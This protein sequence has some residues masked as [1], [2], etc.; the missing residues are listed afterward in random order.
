M[1][2]IVE[3]L[4]YTYGKKSP[5]EKKALDDV[6]FT[7]SDGEFV[8]IVGCTGS[9]KS[10]LVQHLNAL[11]RLTDGKIVVDDVDLTK[12]KPDLQKLRKK[13]GMLFQYPEYQLFAETVLD[14]VK[15][16]PKNFGMKDEEATEA[17][18]RAI[19]LVGLNFDEIKNRS[20]IEI[21]GG[22]KRRVAVAGVLAY[23]PD[24]LIL[25][26]PTAGLDPLGKRDMLDLLASLRSSGAVKTII[27]VSHNMD[28]IAEYAD[29][30]IAL[31][32]GKVIADGS[33]EEFFYSSVCPPALTPPH[34]VSI[35]KKLAENSIVLPC[36]PLTKTQ[37]ISALDDYFGRAK[38]VKNE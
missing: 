31:D 33:P 10:T 21:S 15:F 19:E 9:G 27:T 35:T 6:S 18:K 38:G 28:E 14:D 26:E 22:Q 34:A 5:F 32:Q 23:A 37:L 2:I 13:I 24:F 36:R 30:V 29:R 3:K 7:I 4:S 17:A 8:G 16:G 11:I 1:P 20:P 25:D 12:R